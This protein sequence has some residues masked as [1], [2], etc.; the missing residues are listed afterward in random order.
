M[1][2][3]A[4]GEVKAQE[5]SANGKEATEQTVSISSKL[6]AKLVVIMVNL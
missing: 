4:E 5:E 3:K 2:D 6:E 1:S